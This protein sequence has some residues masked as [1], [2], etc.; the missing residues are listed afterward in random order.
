MQSQRRLNITTLKSVHVLKQSSKGFKW[1]R[2]EEGWVVTSVFFIVLARARAWL[3]LANSPTC[4]HPFFYYYFKIHI[5]V[6]TYCTEVLLNKVSLL[7]ILSPTEAYLFDNRNIFTPGNIFFKVCTVPNG[8]HLFMQIPNLAFATC[9]KQNLRPHSYVHQFETTGTLVQLKLA[10]RCFR[11]C[12]SFLHLWVRH[13][14]CLWVRVS[15]TSW[16]VLKVLA[17]EGWDSTFEIK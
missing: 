13:F 5:H 1:K 10:G 8:N 15:D 7:P 16:D 11:N 6:K 4:L 17:G 12:G 2:M 3:P 14:F 9:I